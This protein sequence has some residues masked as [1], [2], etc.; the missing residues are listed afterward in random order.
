MVLFILSA[1]LAVSQAQDGTCDYGTNLADISRMEWT[2]ESFSDFHGC[3]EGSSLYQKASGAY[4]MCASKMTL[5]LRC[6]P[7]NLETSYSSNF[8]DDQCPPICELGIGVEGAWSW[9]GQVVESC[10]H[11]TTG[12]Y[13]GL[14]SDE[15][16]WSDCVLTQMGDGRD[17]LGLL[18]PAGFPRN[19]E[20]Q[21]GLKALNPSV[22]ENFSNGTTVKERWNNCRDKFGYQKFMM[23]KASEC[24]E[25]YT[26]EEKKAMKFYGSRLD[27]IRCLT[28]ELGDAC[29]KAGFGFDPADRA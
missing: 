16:K 10:V 8:E 29:Y 12:S 13:D 1:L 5:G 18:A 15:T 17:G 6:E 7:C 24:G 21:K 20:I 27:A 19:R 11:H 9:E 2:R 26:D 4:L 22:I 14:C 23:A 25:V 3:L 28:E